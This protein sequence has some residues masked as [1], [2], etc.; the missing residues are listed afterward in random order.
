MSNV[1][2][3]TAEDHNRAVRATPLDSII[4]EVAA[5]TGVH[6]RLIRGRSRE[7]SVVAARWLAWSVAHREGMSLA[8]I[9][10]RMGFDHTSVLHG[11][12]REAQARGHA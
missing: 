8:E 3:L 2:Y 6:E 11:V 9:G 10:R 12:R 7:R 5:A 1:R 4:A